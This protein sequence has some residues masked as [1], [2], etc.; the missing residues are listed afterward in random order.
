MARLRASWRTSLPVVQQPRNPQSESIAR[1]PY[2]LYGDSYS[3]GRRNRKTLPALRPPKTLKPKGLS[4]YILGEDA[5][6][7]GQR[8]QK[9]V[10]GQKGEF[11]YLFVKP[12]RKRRKPLQESSC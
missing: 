6:Y 10:S 12:R 8:W 4:S 9:V 11:A 1:S 5:W 7:H 2:H 3:P